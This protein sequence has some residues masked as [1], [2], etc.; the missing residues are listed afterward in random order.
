MAQADDAGRWPVAGALPSQ[1]RWP[2][3]EASS[4]A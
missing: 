4:H 2:V 1:G 3:E